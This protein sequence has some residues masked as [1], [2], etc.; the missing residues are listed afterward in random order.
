MRTVSR[1]LLWENGVCCNFAGTVT[2]YLGMR[3]WR[4]EAVGA[5]PADGI[6]YGN[7]GRAAVNQ[8]R[9]STGICT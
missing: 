9:K 2:D 6:H 7:M 4:M 8:V 3:S 5:M 1:P